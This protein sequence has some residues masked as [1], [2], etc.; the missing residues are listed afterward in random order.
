MSEKLGVLDMPSEQYHRHPTS[1]SSTGAR[2]IVNDCPATF[3]YLQDNQ[4][5]K[6]EFDIGTAAHL[7]VLEPE[8]FGEKAVLLDVADYKT[9]AAQRPAMQRG[10][11]AKHR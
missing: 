1:L 11:L 10:P 3:R 7:L 9:K 8:R 6:R 5:N 2:Q 4:Q